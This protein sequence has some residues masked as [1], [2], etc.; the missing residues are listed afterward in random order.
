MW[1]LVGHPAVAY[2]QL[3]Q[4]EATYGVLFYLLDGLLVHFK[5][6]TSFALNFCYKHHSDTHLY[7]LVDRDNRQKKHLVYQHSTKAMTRAGITD[8]QAKLKSTPTP[9]EK[10]VYFNKKL[11]NLE[12]PNS[13][14]LMPAQMMTLKHDIT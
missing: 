6:T 10:V 7:T 4:H 9:Q 14:S 2:L 13:S 1:R 12:H 5:V 11:L 8:F 3:P